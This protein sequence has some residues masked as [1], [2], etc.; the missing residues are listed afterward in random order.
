LQL[1]A[2]EVVLVIRPVVLGISMAAQVPVLLLPAVPQVMNLLV[3]QDMQTQAV[4]VAAGVAVALLV[5][6][7]EQAVVAALLSI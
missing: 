1:V 3:M 5:N 6:R 4:V 7:V 2:V